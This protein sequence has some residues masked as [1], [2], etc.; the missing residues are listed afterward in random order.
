MAINSTLRLLYLRDSVSI[1]QVMDAFK[2]FVKINDVLFVQENYLDF[3]IWEKQPDLFGVAFIPIEC[4]DIDA[5]KGDKRWLLI[6]FSDLPQTLLGWDTYLARE[7]NT[8]LEI[9]H[10]YEMSEEYSKFILGDKKS[11]EPTADGIEWYVP[12]DYYQI[13]SL[14]IKN[15]GVKRLAVFRSNDKTIYK[16]W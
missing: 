5:W 9:H 8:F 6:Y 12:H 7:F 14:N 3:E 11:T 16:K 2:A 10:I 13:W 1:D 4:F 15:D